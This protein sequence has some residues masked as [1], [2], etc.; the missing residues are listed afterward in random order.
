[1]MSTGDPGMDTEDEAQEMVSDPPEEVPSEDDVA[2]EAT[3]PSKKRVRVDLKEV[4]HLQSACMNLLKGNDKED[5]T[6]LASFLSDIQ[7]VVSVRAMEKIYRFFYDFTESMT[8]LKLKRKCKKSYRYMRRKM[9]LTA[10]AVL[11]DILLSDGTTMPNQEVV[12]RREDIVRQVNKVSLQAVINHVYKQHGVKGE[13]EKAGF[14]ITQFMTRIIGVYCI[15]NF[16]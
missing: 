5:L 9:I 16:I 2:S 14:F 1:M 8:R 11:V 4:E 15:W 12:S 13:T 3:S 10:P 7:T 6:M